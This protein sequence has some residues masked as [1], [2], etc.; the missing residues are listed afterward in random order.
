M[1]FP[2]RPKLKNSTYVVSI[3]NITDLLLFKDKEDELTFKK[4]SIDFGF[5]YH[6]NVYC[7]SLNDNLVNLS[8]FDSKGN[9]SQFIKCLTGRY[10]KWYNKKYKRKGTIYK[11]RFKSNLIGGSPKNKLAGNTTLESLT[12]N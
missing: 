6:I 12:I 11:R 7:Y 3:E 4:F 1:G 8:L 2:L 9:L 5:I 10:C